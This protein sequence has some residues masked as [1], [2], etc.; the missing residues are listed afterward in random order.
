M[1]IDRTARIW[2]GVN[3]AVV[4]AGIVIQLF[5]TADGTEGFFTEPLPRV[6]N[7]FCF[8]TVQT[9]IIVGVTSLML[10]AGWASPSTVFRVFRLIG[11]VGITVTFI[12][13]QIALRPLQDLTGNAALADF[14]LH[15]ASPILCV[16][17]W[18]WFGPRGQTTARV[19]WWTLSYLV[20]WGAFTLVRGHVIGFYP[21]GFMNPIEHGYARV[22]VNLAIVAVVFV[23]LAAGAH[24]LDGVLSRRSTAAGAPPS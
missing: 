6:L 1:S 7:V 5:V 14:L 16:V 24:L 20:V 21:Y 2:F 12:V 22:T 4:A 23:G 18:L 9:N 17:G 11:V 10:A 13:F 15:T 19:V 3:A 8:F